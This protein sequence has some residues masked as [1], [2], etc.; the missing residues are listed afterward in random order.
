MQGHCPI[1]GGGAGPFSLTLE[2]GRWSLH[3]WVFEPQPQSPPC[4]HAGASR[5][6]AATFFCL[7]TVVRSSSCLFI[8]LSIHPSIHPFIDG[9]KTVRSGLH[10]ALPKDTHSSLDTVNATFFR[11]GVFADAVKDPEIRLP[12]I[13]WVAL[14][15]MTGVL[16][17]E[18]NAEEERPL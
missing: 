16:T 7:L 18:K 1:R 14:N 3:C 15:P 5:Y 11:K 4:V 13:I 10:G 2:T 17:R 6:P 9:E 8:H 12:Y